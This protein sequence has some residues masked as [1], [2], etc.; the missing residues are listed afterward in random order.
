MMVLAAGHTGTT[1]DEAI[2]RLAANFLSFCASQI[3]K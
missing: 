2:K 1:D 3:N